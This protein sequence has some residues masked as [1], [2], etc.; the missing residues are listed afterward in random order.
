LNPLTQSCSSFNGKVCARDESCSGDSAPSIDGSCCTGTCNKIVDYTC[1]QGANMYCKSSCGSGETAMS[2]ETCESGVCCKVTP[3]TPSGS[4]TWIWI[5]LL[6]ILIVL[7][8]IAILM[9]DKIRLAWYKYKG[10]AKTTPV[11]TRPTG[12]PGFRPMQRMMPMRR[13]QGPMQR[14]MPLQRRPT[15]PPAKK[16]ASAKDIEMEETLRKL[17]DM[18]S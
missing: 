2:A 6:A 16:P 15:V 5:L 1:E 14:P 12:P 11:A 4:K 8:I 7:V 3:T 10:N 18:S 9:R 13:V 17:R